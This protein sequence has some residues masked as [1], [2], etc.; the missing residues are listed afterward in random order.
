MKNDFWNRKAREILIGWRIPQNANM[1]EA[2]QKV[3][4]ELETA[5]NA[6]KKAKQAS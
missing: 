2:L 6:G 5:Y 3:A 1:D 4:N